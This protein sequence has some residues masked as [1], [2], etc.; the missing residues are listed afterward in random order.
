MPA[1][2]HLT[3]HY[4]NRDNTYHKR[5]WQFFSNQTQS[6][7]RLGSERIQNRKKFN[8]VQENSVWPSSELRNKIN[9]WQ[10]FFT[11]EIEILNKNQAEILE[12]KNSINALEIISNRA[13]QMIRWKRG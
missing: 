6:H 3:K 5:K 13:D 2:A 7:W 1:E 10:D 11:K 4:E 9:E 8:K 12:L